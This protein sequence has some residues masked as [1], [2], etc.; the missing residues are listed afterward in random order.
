MK[1]TKRSFLAGMMKMYIQF[2]ENI[3]RLNLYLPIQN[4]AKIFPN[5][6]SFV[7]SPVISPRN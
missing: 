7:I 6:S 1:E 4:F 5:T 3:S 2:N